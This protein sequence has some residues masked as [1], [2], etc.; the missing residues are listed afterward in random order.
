MYLRFNLDM[1]ERDFLTAT[2]AI[3]KRGLKKKKKKNKD[4]TLCTQCLKNACLVFILKMTFFKLLKCTVAKPPIC[5]SCFCNEQLN[6]NVK[7]GKEDFT[8]NV[9]NIVLVIFKSFITFCWGKKED[10][11]KKSHIKSQS[12]YFGKKSQLDYFPKSF[13]PKTNMMR[14]RPV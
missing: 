7:C 12:Q 9:S 6:T 4:S 8:L 1:I 11:K 2:F 5:C 13:S 14:K 10:K 3:K